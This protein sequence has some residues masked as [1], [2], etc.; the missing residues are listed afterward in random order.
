MDMKKI[1]ENA[2][3]K[4]SEEV[5]TVGNL[6]VDA[7]GVVIGENAIDIEAKEVSSR[8]IYAEV[9]FYANQV[10]LSFDPVTK[11]LIKESINLKFILDMKFND[12]GSVAEAEFVDIWA[13][14]LNK[15]E[16]LDLFRD[17][18]K[19]TIPLEKVLV[20]LTERE[21]AKTTKKGR[22]TSII[23]QIQSIATRDQYDEYLNRSF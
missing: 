19:N 3:A 15:P 23:R 13:T 4:A 12:N 14:T 17:I 22:E 1:H 9:G 21:M 10:Y 8:V 11:E 5:K 20:K 7:D 6:K 16:M 18:I 2:K